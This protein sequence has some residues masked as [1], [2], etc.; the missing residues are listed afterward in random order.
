MTLPLSHSGP[1]GWW[2]GGGGGGILIFLYICRL[3]AFFGVKNFEF[4]YFGVFFR[5]MNIF[6]DMKILWIFFGGSSQNW[7]NFRS[8]FYAFRGRFLWSR[9]KMGDIFWVTKISNIF[10]GA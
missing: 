5:K 8:H 7:A 4:Q 6:L 3:G 10:W 1:Q 9:Y 2:W